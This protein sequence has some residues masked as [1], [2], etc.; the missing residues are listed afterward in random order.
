MT[1]KSFTNWQGCWWETLSRYNLYIVYRA[2]K[3]NP[4]DTS[5][6]Q[7]DYASVLEASCTATILTK[8]CNSMFCLWQLYPT[9]VQEDKIFEDLL[10]DTLA[11]LILEGRQMITLQRRPA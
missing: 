3:E 10:P 11:D 2:G 6:H 9:N 4:A 1:T 5:R 7:L 8:C